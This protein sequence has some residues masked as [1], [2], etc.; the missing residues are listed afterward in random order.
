MYLPHSPQTLLYHRPL[1]KNEFTV[2]SW[3][4]HHRKQGGHHWN[5]GGHNLLSKSVDEHSQHT[6]VFTTG[7]STVL[8]CLWESQ[9]CKFTQVYAAET[10]QIV[11]HRGMRA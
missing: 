4:L 6:F 2:S 3:T 5:S 10:E 11:L 7:T 8:I 9:V 1:G